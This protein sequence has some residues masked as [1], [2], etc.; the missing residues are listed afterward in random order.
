MSVS[1]WPAPGLD[2]TQLSK[3][4][5]P[6]ELHRAQVTDRRVSTFRVVETLDIVKHICLCLIARP[7]RFVTGALG[8][9]RREEALHRGVVPHIARSAHRTDDAAVGQ[10][11][12][13]LLARVLAAAIRVMQQ[14]IELRR[15]H[16]PRR[17]PPAKIR[18][19]TGTATF[20]L[21]GGCPKKWKRR[22]SKK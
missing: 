14:R 12:L 4:G 9:Q 6:L 10:Q 21:R 7:V 19:P 18:K 15:R 17:Q 2:D 1:L 5:L 20:T 3:S 8:L 16:Q 13:E 22:T 11:P